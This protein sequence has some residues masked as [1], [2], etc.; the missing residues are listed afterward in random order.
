MLRSPYAVK[1]W[2][3]GRMRKGEERMDLQAESIM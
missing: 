3:G 1:K 2:L